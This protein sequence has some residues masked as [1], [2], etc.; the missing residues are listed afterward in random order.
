MNIKDKFNVITAV[1]IFIKK[2]Y[3]KKLINYFYFFL[4]TTIVA[5]VILIFNLTS[6]K[7]NKLNIFKT[8][9]N[10]SQKI[11]N[12]NIAKDHY[13]TKNLIQ[14]LYYVQ[15]FENDFYALNEGCE[16]IISVYAENKK[17]SDLARSSNHCLLARKSIGIASDGLAMSLSMVGG[18]QD[19]INIISSIDY[20]SNSQALAA[21]AQLYAY[22][23]KKALAKQHL[24]QAIDIGKP[25][26]PWVQRIFSHRTFYSDSEFLSK[27]TDLITTKKDYD[28][29]KFK[30]IMT[31]LKQKKHQ[32]HALKKDN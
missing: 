18:S 17:Y 20:S 10:N 31:K 32:L 26:S 15:N 25:W 14:A 8:F 6:L 4:I 13:F 21:L 5:S 29:E 12:F 22:I 7:F 16:L 30:N 28:P 2:K 19:A 1:K 27:V 23:D 24:L 9:N 3:H 11:K